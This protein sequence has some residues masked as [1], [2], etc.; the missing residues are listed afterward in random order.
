MAVVQAE[1]MGNQI[2]NMVMERDG[3]ILDIFLKVQPTGFP[4]EL[5][6]GCEKKKIKLSLNFLVS[7]NERMS[8]PSNVM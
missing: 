8:L 3:Q 2:R 4:D 6:V 5:D 7:A 1:M